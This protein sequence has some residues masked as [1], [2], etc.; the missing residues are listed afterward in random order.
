MKRKKKVLNSNRLLLLQQTKAIQAM[1]NVKNASTMVQ[2]GSQTCDAGVQVQDLSSGDDCFRK[3][4]DGTRESDEDLQETNET[5]KKKK[6]VMVAKDKKNKEGMIKENK[7]KIDKRK[8]VKTRDMR[9]KAKA[10]PVQKCKVVNEDKE[11]ENEMIDKKTTKK[12]LRK[13]KSQPES[14]TCQNETKTRAEKQHATTSTHEKSTTEVEFQERDDASN[15]WLSPSASPGD[16]I[17]FKYSTTPERLQKLEE[18]RKSLEKPA[19]QAGVSAQ[20]TSGSSEETNRSKK[21]SEVSLEKLPLIAVCIED[22][23]NKE[24]VENEEEVKEM[25]EVLQDHKD[26]AEEFLSQNQSARNEGVSPEKQKSLM[27]EEDRK[28]LDLNEAQIQLQDEEEVLEDSEKTNACKDIQG[29]ELAGAQDVNERMQEKCK[30]KKDSKRKPKSR[31][32]KSVAEHIPQDKGNSVDETNDS[33]AK[34]V[35]RSRT[36][37]RNSGVE[38]D[39][40]NGEE[41][42]SLGKEARQKPRDSDVETG[43]TRKHETVVGYLQGRELAMLDKSSHE[44]DQF[45]RE[46]DM[47]S[48]E[49]DRFV[50]EPRPSRGVTSR[51][52]AGDETSKQQTEP[53][54]LGELNEEATTAQGER[55][56][57]Y[58]SDQGS[59]ALN[60]NRIR[61]ED[62]AIFHGCLHKALE[63]EKSTCQNGPDP[64]EKNVKNKVDLSAKNKNITREAQ[65]FQDVNDVSASK[66]QDSDT[67]EADYNKHLSREV[68]KSASRD[69]GRAKRDGQ[70]PAGVSALPAASSK[71]NASDGKLKGRRK[72]YVMIHFFALVIKLF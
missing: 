11:K 28:L 61:K 48:R 9:V 55:L 35:L 40:N 51:E 10:K 41:R 15:S 37:K 33:Q 71:E 21:G 45:P 62:D 60:D 18:G 72:R 25:K 46:T 3:N 1:V 14:V 47:S 32:I 43:A 22:I 26:G 30:G 50:D 17:P 16:D 6:E 31:Q 5:G 59:L 8:N 57:D 70:D 36:K 27:I 38:Q 34:R 54:V 24:T 67:N 44:A 64:L 29:E 13:R 56:K 53:E 20:D 52:P 19:N 23:L 65:L 4:G 42:K 2:V 39:T 69:T 7:P 49:I 66:K 63:E 58:K 68:A 12:G